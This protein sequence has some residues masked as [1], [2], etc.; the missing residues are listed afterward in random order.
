MRNINDMKWNMLQSRGR[1]LG[2]GIRFSSLAFKIKSM[3]LQLR[4]TKAYR[5]SYCLH[6]V[7]GIIGKIGSPPI[8][9]PDFATA[10]LTSLIKVFYYILFLFQF[11][12]FTLNTICFVPNRQHLQPQTL[13]HYIQTSEDVPFEERNMQYLKKH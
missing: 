5:N 4:R 12:V 13:S 7:D 9:E 6:L 10:L 8:S 2:N 11:L 1:W 3:A